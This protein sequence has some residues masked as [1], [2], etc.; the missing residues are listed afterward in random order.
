[1]GIAEIT[2]SATSPALTLR[3]VRTTAV[4]VR[5]RFVLGTSAAVVRAEPPLLVD[6]ESQQGVT[7]RACIFCCRQ[8]AAQ[9]IADLLQD[10]AE[11]DSGPRDSRSASKGSTA[12]R[13]RLRGDGAVVVRRHRVEQRHGR[14]SS[15]LMMLGG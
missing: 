10:T 2:L 15:I 9:G 6:A 11:T 3:C 4:E 7:G 13:E 12:H 5:L 8:S 14:S 1:V